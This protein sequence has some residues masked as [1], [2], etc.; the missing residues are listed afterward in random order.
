MINYYKVYIKCFNQNLFRLMFVL[1]KDKYKIRFCNVL[2]AKAI[3]EGIII[4]IRSVKR[5][6]F[7]P[8]LRNY[9]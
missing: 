3:A 7:F 9:S 1:S 6:L 2:W 8:F 5:T 4:R